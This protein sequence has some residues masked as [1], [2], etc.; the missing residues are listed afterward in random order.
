MKNKRKDEY[1]QQIVKYQYL[2]FIVSSYFF[3]FSK[4]ASY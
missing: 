2:I 4:V 1:K 3:S